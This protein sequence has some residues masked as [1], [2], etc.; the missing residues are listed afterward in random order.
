M[1]RS[2]SITQTLLTFQNKNTNNPKR[3]ADFFNNHSSTIRKKTK[4]K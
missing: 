2:S 1:K 3:V 4:L